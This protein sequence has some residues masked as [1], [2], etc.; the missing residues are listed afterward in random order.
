MPLDANEAE[1]I[2]LREML[3][4]QTRVIGQFQGELRVERAIVDFWSIEAARLYRL[5]SMDDDQLNA[6]A[7]GQDRWP[8]GMDIEAWHARNR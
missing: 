4:W 7:R 8:I 6:L 2:R 5:A 1:L 3:K